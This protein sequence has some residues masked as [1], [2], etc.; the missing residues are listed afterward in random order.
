VL[1][2]H[3]VAFR[4]WLFCTRNP[5]SRG[6]PFRPPE[7]PDTFWSFK[8]AL[9]SIRKKTALATLGFLTIAAMLPG[10]WPKKLVDM[11]VT[12]L[13][14]DDLA[15]VD[16]AFVGGMVVQRNSARQTIAKCKEAGLK[17][18]AGGPL[19][20]SEYDHFEDV[21]HFVL[22]EAELTQNKKRNLL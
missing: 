4:P 14:E 16:C 7:F 11:N 13:T 8:H 19:F 22:N 9:K 10:E 6:F 3:H 1:S 20:T 17:V 12:K 21:D 2:R 5:A 15:W 18:I